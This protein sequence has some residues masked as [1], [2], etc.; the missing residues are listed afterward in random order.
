MNVFAKVYSDF[1]NF[2]GVCK[3]RGGSKTWTYPS[4]DMDLLHTSNTIVPKL[5]KCSKSRPEDRFNSN[6]KKWRL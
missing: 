4:P 1:G 5:N 2:T 3:E 6:S